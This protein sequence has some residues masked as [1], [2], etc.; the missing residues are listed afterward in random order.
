MARKGSENMT[1]TMDAPPMDAAGAELMPVTIV[2]VGRQRVGKTTLLNATA[3]YYRKRGANLQVWNAD[4]QNTTNNLT[5]FHGDAV[6]APSGS[7]S[8]VVDW[9]EER[10]RDQT[11]HRYDVI[12]DVGGGET[13]LNRL[14]QELRLVEALERRKIRVVGVHLL[15]PDPADL[16]YLRRFMESRTFMPKATLMVMNEGLITSGNSSAVAFQEATRTRR[17]STRSGRR[18]GGRRRCRRFSG[19]SRRP[20]CRASPHRE[21]ARDMDGSIKPGMRGTE[22][23]VTTAMANLAERTEELRRAMSEFGVRPGHPESVLLHA[24]TS[25]QL[26]FGDMAAE[27]ALAVANTQEGAKALVEAEIREL[28]EAIRVAEAV[29]AQAKAAAAATEV[30]RD[31][32]IES[33][34]A[35][36]AP[37]LVDKLGGTLVIKA[38][39]YERRRRLLFYLQDLRRCQRRGTLPG[40]G[41]ACPRWPGLVPGGECAWHAAARAGAA[42]AGAGAAVTERPALTPAVIR[43]TVWK[44]HRRREGGDGDEAVS[45]GL[46]GGRLDD[47]AGHGHGGR[48]WHAGAG[49]I[50]RGQHE[51]GARAGDPACDGAGARL[52]HDH[53]DPG[54]R[55]AGHQQLGDRVG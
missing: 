51:R 22:E 1:T 20:G 15:G 52:V 23:I 43:T 19:A 49:T 33:M 48:A 31:Q 11:R 50:G 6:S 21:R 55:H 35:K 37:G 38:R 30:Q 25:S 16:D 12:L 7:M 2:A 27:M 47:R 54:F 17:S 3:Q 53:A 24:M 41:G 40:R 10:I 34:I 18:S 29:T 9:L 36:V 46:P 28:R 42:G 26:A 14:V 32:V 4:H 39:Q 13:A 8:D 45:R 44:G 5:A